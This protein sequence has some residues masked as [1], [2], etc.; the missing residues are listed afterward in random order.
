MFKN[1]S[2]DKVF[3]ICYVAIHN[4]I[5]ISEIA[6][7][8]ALYN[9][10]VERLQEGFN[11]FKQAENI[12]IQYLALKGDKQQATRK[13]NKART[14]ANKTY[15]RHLKLARLVFQGN[16]EVWKTLGLDGRRPEA[17]AEW[18]AQARR[19]YTN[20]S[21]DA[22]IRT[23]LLPYN[24]TEA[25]LHEGLTLL[26]EAETALAAREKAHGILIQATRSRDMALQTLKAWVSEMLTVARIVFEDRPH[27]LEA[28]GLTVK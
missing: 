18:L 22:D 28:L 12:S 6:E 27:L 3:E 14:I 20:A 26:A 4:A 24:I 2:S 5:N 7:T 8:L 15:I 11:L 19:F 1:K 23:A 9:Y 13:I 21:N 16:V 25:D 17:F 10:P